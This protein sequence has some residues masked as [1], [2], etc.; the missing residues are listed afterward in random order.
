MSPLINTKVFGPL[1]LTNLR[2][3]IKFHLLNNSAW[4]P[5]VLVVAV[6][7]S[8]GSNLFIPE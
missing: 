1:N 7:G 8:F 3:S 6:D 5:S 2:G 4:L